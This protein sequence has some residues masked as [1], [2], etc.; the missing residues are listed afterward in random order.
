MTSI[1]TSDGI[2][3]YSG[4]IHSGDLP[5]LP[6]VIRHNQST[7][8]HERHGIPLALGLEEISNDMEEDV[9]E[10]T[11]SL[12]MAESSIPNSGLGVYAGIDI[13]RSDLVD[14]MPQVL[15]PLIDFKEKKK[16]LWDYLW[17]ADWYGGTLENAEL[18]ILTTNIGMMANSHLGLVNS[19]PRSEKGIHIHV[20]SED[21]TSNFGAGANT[22]NHYTGFSADIEIKH[23]SEIFT[24]YGV[25]YF[26]HREKQFNLVFPSLDDYNKADSIVRDFAEKLGDTITEDDAKSWADIVQRVK[27]DDEKIRVA[28]ALPDSVEDVAYVAEV[29]TARYSLPGSSR[30]MEWLEDNG[31]CLDSIRMGKSDIPNALFGKYGRK[32]SVEI[33]QCFDYIPLTNY[34]LYRRLCNESNEKGLT[35]RTNAT[36][37]NDKARFTNAEGR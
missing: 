37:T 24:D 34:C 21:R 32:A 36:G 3:T 29:G 11:C 4:I 5:N 14:D 20:D 27:D 16:I 10:Q 1:C 2:C 13:A 19:N 9:I 18:K 28:Y 30:S 35:Y 7:Y 17:D 15:I 6:T 25:S 12:Y 31:M 22:L 23:G 26:Q 33:F 8:L